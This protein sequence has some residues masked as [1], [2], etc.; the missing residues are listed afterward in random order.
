[1]S[2]QVDLSHREVQIAQAYAGGAA[3]GGD[4]GPLGAGGPSF[5][6]LGMRDPGTARAPGGLLQRVQIIK[7]WADDD[8]RIHQEIHDIAGS[9]DNGASVDLA[10]CEPSGPGYDVLCRVW[11]DPDFDPKRR[12]V[13][14]AR[15]VENPSCRFST[16]H[17]L[18]IEPEKRPEAC[19]NDD[20]PKTIQERA[21]SSP[22]WYTPPT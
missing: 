1:M 20:V 6:A 22:I 11:R 21:W 4:L 3:M 19:S 16:W 7:G 18:E 12:A 17:C 15:V 13:Y 14:Y 2:G 5:V 8:G 10:T 9:A